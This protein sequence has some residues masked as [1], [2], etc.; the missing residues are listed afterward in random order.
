MHIVKTKL[1]TVEEVFSKIKH[2]LATGKG[3]S[4]ARFGNGEAIVMAQGALIPAQVPF[5]LEYAGVKQPDAEMRQN[6]IAAMHEADIVG[7][8]TDHKN[9]DCAPLLEKVLTAYQINPRYL[10]DAAINW[11]LHR[12]HQFYR[13][14]GKYPTA[15]VGRLAHA[16]APYL[17]ARGVQIVNCLTLESYS[18]L[19]A[20]ESQLIGGPHFR[21]ALV[22]AGIPATVLCPRLARK[23]G[24]LAI[25]YGHIIND[26]LK[27]GFSNKDLP[28]ATAEWLQSKRLN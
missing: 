3:L 15:V 16:A 22:A 12:H 1:H 6:L 13:T 5:W 26:L 23:T 14:I 2:A 21:V 4:L 28:Q 9:W 10:T 18:D 19:P 7:L 20:V 25:D 17:A 27:P 24:C 11:Q 8:S